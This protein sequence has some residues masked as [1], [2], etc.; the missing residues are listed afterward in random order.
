[1]SPFI[2]SKFLNGFIDA[3]FVEMLEGSGGGGGGGNGG[4]G[5]GFGGGGELD[6]FVILCDDKIGDEDDNEIT[7]EDNG[8]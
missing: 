1:M 2:S 7:E 5:G 3:E 4:G 6:S 8:F